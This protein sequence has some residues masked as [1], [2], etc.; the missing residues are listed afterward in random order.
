[1]SAIRQ[2]ISIAA[3]VR[4]VWRALTTNDGLTSWWVDEARV[5]ARAG[6]TVTLTAEDDDGNPRE[7]RGIFHSIVPTRKIEIHW[8]QGSPAP[9]CG[10]RIQFSLARDRGETRLS[11]IHSGGD[12]GDDE[13]LHDLLEK[14]WRQSLFALRSYLED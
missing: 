8:D 12:V 5:D 2:Q 6:G 1:M 13:E 14:E 7:E 9:T 11:V 3:A 10:S 4:T